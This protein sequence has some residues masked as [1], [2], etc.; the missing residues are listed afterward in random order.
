MYGV[1]GRFAVGRRSALAATLLTALWVVL[2]AGI[3]NSATG[4]A[5]VPVPPAVYVGLAL[6]YLLVACI[7]TGAQLRRTAVV[8]AIMLVTQALMSLF[9]GLMYIAMAGNGVGA[10][11]AWLY[12]IADYLPGLLLQAVVVFLMGPVVAAWWGGPQ[13]E[14]QRH[15]IAQLPAFSTAGSVQDAL[16]TICRSPDIAGV[17]LCDGEQTLGGGIWYRDPAA[18][19]DRVRLLTGGTD[20]DADL[21]ILGEAAIAVS[22]RKERTVA[23]ALPDADTGHLAPPVTQR[24]H[25]IARKLPATAPTQPD[26]DRDADDAETS[27]DEE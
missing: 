10:A 4:M 14:Q 7:S 21:F 25:R 8:F 27:T 2:L 9:A 1:E 12:A 23:V 6:A 18:A 22:V 15:R 5:R 24:L 26:A 3:L 13:A 19:C 20:K 16:D 17:L 11:A